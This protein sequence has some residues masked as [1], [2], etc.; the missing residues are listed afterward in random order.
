MK[1]KVTLPLFFLCFSLLGSPVAGGLPYAVAANA[2]PAPEAQKAPVAKKQPTAQ[3][4]PVAQKPQAAKPA[5]AQQPKTSAAKTAPPKKSGQQAGKEQ[6][7]RQKTAASPKNQSAPVKQS[8]GEKVQ[9]ALD[10]FAKDCIIRMNRQRR[11]G[12]S[13]KEVKRQSDGTY[14]A[15]YMAVDPDSLA[16]SYNPTE[17]NKTIKFIGRMDYHEVEYI[18]TGKDQKQALAGPFSETNRT[19]ITELIKYK[20]GKWTY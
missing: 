13:H 15:R 17:N 18:C 11:P 6:A 12:I 16:T 10:V 8:D 19:P 3:K 4:A 5:E 1:I 14:L 9:T 20:S 7:P 2:Q